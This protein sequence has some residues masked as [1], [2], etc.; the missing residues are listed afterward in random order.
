M[1]PG[2]KHIRHRIVMHFDCQRCGGRCERVRCPDGLKPT[3]CDECRIRDW[4]KRRRE[5]RAAAKAERSMPSLSGGM[6]VVSEDLLREHPARARQTS[7][8]R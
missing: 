1:Y 6:Q 3:V 4:N 8:A 7:G 2:G 5:K